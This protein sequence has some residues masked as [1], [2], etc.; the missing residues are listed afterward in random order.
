[1]QYGEFWEPAPYYADP[2][3]P[4]YTPYEPEVAFITAAPEPWGPGPLPRNEPEARP[5]RYE[6][7]LMIESLC[8]RELRARG[9]LDPILD[10]LSPDEERSLESRL[11]PP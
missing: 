3:N 9:E 1:V 11:E 5:A 4:F 2:T 6:D 7:M 8:R 10:R